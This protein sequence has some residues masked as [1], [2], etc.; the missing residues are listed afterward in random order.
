MGLVQDRNFGLSHSLSRPL[1]DE[2]SIRLASH[3]A[4]NI[5][6]PSSHGKGISIE[7]GRSG[8][9]NTEVSSLKEEIGI[10]K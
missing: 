5:S 2:A 9:G 10:L 8:D 3:L 4:Q 6:E 1:L 7:E